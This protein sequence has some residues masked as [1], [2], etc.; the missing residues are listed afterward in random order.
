MKTLKSF[1][2]VDYDHFTMIF[3][4]SLETLKIADDMDL[5]TIS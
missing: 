3:P 5:K 1:R 4:F 2:E